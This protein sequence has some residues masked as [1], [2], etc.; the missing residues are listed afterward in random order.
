M[1]NDGRKSLMIGQEAHAH[2]MQL[3]ATFNVSQPEMV[4]ALIRSVDKMRLQATLTEMAEKRKLTAAEAQQKR[5]LIENALRE[6][7]AED[8]KRL[9]AAAKA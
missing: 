6:M 3:A 5:I 2:L 8:V 9:L 1:A 4:E 7:T